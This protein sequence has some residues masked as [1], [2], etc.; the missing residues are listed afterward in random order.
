MSH[1]TRSGFAGS[2]FATLAAA[3]PLFIFAAAADEVPRAGQAARLK[4]FAE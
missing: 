4:S 3:L 1:Q 2:P